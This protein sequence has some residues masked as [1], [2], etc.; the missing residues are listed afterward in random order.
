MPFKCMR[1]CICHETFSQNW[2]SA[3][4]VDMKPALEKSLQNKG[5]KY[6]IQYSTN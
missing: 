3:L 5:I 1:L 6:Q 4:D 2:S